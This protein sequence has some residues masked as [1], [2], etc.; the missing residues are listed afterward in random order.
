MLAR[1]SRASTSSTMN[2][3][4]QGTLGP[5]LK[6]LRG[7]GRRR[8]HGLGRRPAGRDDEPLPL[9]LGPRRDARRSWATSKGSTTRTATRRPRRAS[10]ATPVSAHRWR[11]RS[12]TARRCRSRWRSS[13]TRRDSGRPASGCTGPT[14]RRCTTPRTCFPLD[15]LLEIGLVDY[16]VGAEPAPG[17][18]VP[19][20]A[21]PSR[22]EALAGA[23]QARR[24]T[25]LHVLHPVPPVPSRGAPHRRAGRALR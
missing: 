10:P 3:E 21:R 11:R 2:A 16:M 8:A 6:A 22:P 17:V 18:L 25:A 5:M 4:L 15:E 7:P 1:S 24:R 14:R 13:R 19:G 23:V 12:P 20:H 9:R